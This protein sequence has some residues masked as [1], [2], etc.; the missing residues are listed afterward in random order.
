MKFSLTKY[1]VPSVIAMV[2]I[3]TYTNIDGFFIGNAT[4][5]DGLAAI[6]FAWPIIAFAMSIGTGIGVGGSVIVNTLRGKNLAEEGE[7]AKRTSLL[8]LLFAG[9]LTTALMLAL[10]SP[11]LKLM[12]AEGQAL[13]YAENYSLVVSAGALFQVLGAGLVV[14]LRNEGKTV[15]SMLYTF[16]GLVV[17][18]ILD[19][20][21]VKGYALYGVAASTI[22][23]QAVI[24]ALC[25]LSFRIKTKEKF[26]LAH[27]AE[28]VKSSVAPFGLNFVPSAVL[29]FTNYFAAGV[30]GAEAVS[31]Y[32]VMSYAVYTFDYV[33]QG[34]CDGVQP[35]V[36]YCH[37]ADDV[38]QKNRAVKT[39]VTLLV[40]TSVAFIALTPALIAVLPGLFNVSEITAAYIRAGLIIYAFSYPFKAAVKFVCAYNYSVKRNVISNVVTYIDPLLFTPAFLAVLSATCGSNGIWIALPAAQMATSAVAL[41]AS[42]TYKRKLWK[43]CCSN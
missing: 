29:L 39:A 28:I 35:I 8:F 31:A 20:A 9:L 15:L 19:I 23:S 13:I 32:A 5:D 38:A 7:T 6:N 41:V 10:Y 26:N 2:L 34:I 12:G 37:G 25:L 43:N 27:G 21:L 33:Y 30:G 42:M 4:G 40:V 3:G 18:V 24:A 22:A 36:S 11:L 14:L 17:H 16:T 1:I